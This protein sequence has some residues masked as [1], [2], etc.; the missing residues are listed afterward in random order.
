MIALLSEALADSHKG[1][2]GW[3]QKCLDLHGQVIDHEKVRKH[4]SNGNVWSVENSYPS[5][6]QTVS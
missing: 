3:I 2:L 5:D 6:L 1:H 4:L